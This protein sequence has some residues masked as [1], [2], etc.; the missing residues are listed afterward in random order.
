[1]TTNNYR[2]VTK[3]KDNEK[4]INVHMKEMISVLKY[5]EIKTNLYVKG[6]KLSSHAIERCGEMFGVGSA[7]AS[8]M[9]K[10]MLKNAIRIGSVLA[11]DGR[12]NVLYAYNKTAIFLSPDLKMVVTINRYYDDVMYDKVKKILLKTKLT[13]QEVVNLHVKLIRDIEKIEIDLE[14]KILKINNKVEETTNMYKTILEFGKGRS[15]K[16]TVKEMISEHNYMLKIEARKLFELKIQKRHICKSL[17][18][19]V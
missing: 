3:V 14:E 5:N 16:K 15:R 18:N 13:D 6:V 10:D 11:Y 12:Q 9:I 8:K 19:L 7:T 2:Y 4:K 1:M 17:V